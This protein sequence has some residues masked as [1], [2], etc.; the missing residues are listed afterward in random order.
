[1]SL[2][3]LLEQDLVRLA[4]A[5]PQRQSPLEQRSETITDFLN[6]VYDVGRPWALS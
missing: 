3:L 4:E 5:F 2:E 6:R 1:M